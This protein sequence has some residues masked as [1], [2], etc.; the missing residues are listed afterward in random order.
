MEPFYTERL[1]ETLG[2]DY[3]P[4]HSNAEYAFLPSHAGGIGGLTPSHARPSAF[5]RASAPPPGT[6]DFLQ[7]IVPAFRRDW[8][9][10]EQPY[11]DAP[12]S[13]TASLEELSWWPSRG[14][15]PNAHALE[16]GALGAAT[17]LEDLKRDL[18][19]D[20]KPWPVKLAE[21]Y[22]RATEERP[23][24]DLDR[25]RPDEGRQS[26]SRIVSHGYIS[27]A[28]TGSA[29]HEHFQQMQTHHYHPVLA[30]GVNAAFA[31]SEMLA[32]LN[33]ETKIIEGVVCR[34]G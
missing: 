5:T 2:A 9:D 10:L 31:S 14:G 11:A 32:S 21:A 12:Q 17:S 19:H 20:V 15:T 13:H 25:P 16:V 27:G 29:Y 28:R 34:G 33:Q 26:G 8:T 4:H 6:K 24:D 22:M 3:L 23:V 1:Q 30:G 7:T 18:K